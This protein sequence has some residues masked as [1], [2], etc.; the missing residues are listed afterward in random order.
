MALCP[1]CRR[2]ITWDVPACPFCGEEFEGEGGISAAE[3]APGPM[4][5]RDCEPHRGNWL[6]AL[7]NVCMTLGALSLCLCGTGGV[8]AVPLGVVVWVLARNDLA[9]MA[10]GEVDP[11]GRRETE[12]A[13]TA[14]VVGIV[15]SLLFGFFFALMYLSHLGL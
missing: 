2:E 11:G 4:F 7:G 12:N 5:R 1:Y 10:R 13:R 9:R 14:A 15:L 3:L 6:L 8:L